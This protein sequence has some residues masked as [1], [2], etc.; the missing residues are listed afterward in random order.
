M[1]IELDIIATLTTRTDEEKVFF[2]SS[3]W[4]PLACLSL[5]LLHRSTASDLF[6]KC[7]SQLYLNESLTLSRSA[8]PMLIL[9][10]GIIYECLLI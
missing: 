1:I 7:S 3:L 5:L 8:A 6:I 4:T 10:L 9:Y 2:W